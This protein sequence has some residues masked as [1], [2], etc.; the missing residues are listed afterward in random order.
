LSHSSQATKTSGPTCMQGKIDKGDHVGVSGVQVV[1]HPAMH[2]HMLHFNSARRRPSQANKDASCS[3]NCA[4]EQG[5]YSCNAQ[6]TSSPTAQLC[7]KPSPTCP[8][9]PCPANLHAAHQISTHPII[10]P[11]A[12][13]NHAPKHNIHHQLPCAPM[14]LA[15]Q[16]VC[17]CCG[18]RPQLC[19][20]N[21]AHGCAH[22]NSKPAARVVFSTH[23]CPRPLQQPLPA[24]TPCCCRGC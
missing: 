5:L 15:W 16:P 19:S 1:P 9:H 4:H 21:F 17:T 6:P 7:S 2:T 23:T 3:H 18:Y 20:T 24:W 12:R 11:L 22:T 8:K 10:S 13:C 14:P